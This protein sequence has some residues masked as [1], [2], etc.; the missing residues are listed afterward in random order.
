MLDNARAPSTGDEAVGQAYLRVSFPKEYSIW[1]SNIALS[2]IEVAGHEDQSASWTQS[3]GQMSSSGM[4]PNLRENWDFGLTSTNYHNGDWEA[5]CTYHWIR[6]NIWGQIVEEGDSSISDCPFVLNNIVVT[7][8]YDTATNSKNFLVVRDGSVP[9]IH[10]AISAHFYGDARDTITYQV[11]LRTFDTS[12][13]TL[14]PW[15]FTDTLS[16]ATD[17]IDL[18]LDDTL[19]GNPEAPNRGVYAFDVVANAYYAYTSGHWCDGKPAVTPDT[20]TVDIDDETGEKLLA[21]ATYTVSTKAGSSTLLEL[22]GPTEQSGRDLLSLHYESANEAALGSNEFEDFELDNIQVSDV[23]Y[24]GVA[25]LDEDTTDYRSHTARW[26]WATGWRALVPSANLVRG[27]DEPGEIEAEA[28]LTADAVQSNA[29]RG[30][31]ALPCEDAP[32][33]WQ[34]RGSF[35]NIDPDVFGGATT[36]DSLSHEN[37]ITAMETSNVFIFFGHG[38]EDG[39]YPESDER[40]APADLDTNTNLQLGVLLACYSD[41]FDPWFENECPQAAYVTLTD[42]T[43]MSY[44]ALFYG[45]FIQFLTEGTDDYEGLYTIERAS[46][47]AAMTAHRNS[48]KRSPGYRDRFPGQAVCQGNNGHTLDPAIHFTA[49]V[50]GWEEGY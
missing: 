13:S 38:L 6:Y 22:F 31:S 23:H 46:L 41:V 28:G 10:A 44:A 4:Y 21:D 42:K 17:S 11:Y 50:F 34:F 1:Y 40:I 8:A 45:L 5:T 19:T 9:Q 49:P 48:N 36:H 24:L 3:Q 43:D 29:Y 30:L 39:I 2:I 37:I 35:L 18:T 12:P 47:Q 14:G 15:T 26:A 7:D 32:S 27:Y 33:Y 16:G 25:I 20:V